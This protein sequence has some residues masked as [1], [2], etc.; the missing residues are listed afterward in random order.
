MFEKIVTFVKVGTQL[1][2]IVM[3]LVKYFELP[4]AAGKGSDKKD[5]VGALIALAVELIPDEVE[6][7][8]GSNKA[9]KLVAGLVEIVVKFFNAIGV[10]KKAS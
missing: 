2:P 4:E 10:F 9:V 8:I 5:A 7:A 3:E 6:K 1:V